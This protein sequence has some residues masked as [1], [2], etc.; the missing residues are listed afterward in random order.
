MLLKDT[1]QRPTVSGLGCRYLHLS[2]SLLSP[3]S[4]HHSVTVEVGERYR[5]IIGGG[6]ERERE[7]ERGG[8]G[9]GGGGGE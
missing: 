2:A 3:S 4:E 9:G 5:S 7:R 8:G 6:R 1:F